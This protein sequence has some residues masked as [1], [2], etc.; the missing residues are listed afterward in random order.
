MQQFD[1]KR[2]ISTATRLR[3]G[4][5]VVAS[6]LV[7][8]CAADDGATAPAASAPVPAPAPAPAPEPAPQPPRVAAP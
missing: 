3:I 5:V 2:R 6:L 7:T 1:S 8:A 4:A